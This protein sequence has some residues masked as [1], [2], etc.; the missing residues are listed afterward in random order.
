MVV[1]DAPDVSQ[2][3]QHVVLDDR[4]ARRQLFRGDGEVPA[5]EH[6]RED[7][8][9]G[10]EEQEQ[11]DDEVVER[12]VIDVEGD[13]LPVDR[14]GGSEG[15]RVDEPEDHIPFGGIERSEQEGYDADPERIEGGV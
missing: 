4:L 1:G 8:A 15:C 12:E 10:R 6:Q 7:E 2:E 5:V 9:D 14:I 13:V 11:A 3:G